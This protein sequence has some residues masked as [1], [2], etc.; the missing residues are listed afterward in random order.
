[1]EILCL[2][3][4]PRNGVD[5]RTVFRPDNGFVYVQPPRPKISVHGRPYGR[6]T[7]RMETGTTY[8]L[9]Y[10]L[11]DLPI[12]EKNLTSPVVRRKVYGKL[13]TNTTNKLSYTWPNG[14]RPKTCYPQSRLG[15]G[16]SPM[17]TITVHSS[18]YINPG[19]VTTKS[20]KCCRSR[21]PVTAPMESTTIARESYQHPGPTIKSRSMTN[22]SKNRRD[23][24]LSIKP[25]YETIQ[26]L[27]YQRNLVE[28]PTLT[29]SQRRERAIVSAKIGRET[30]YNTSYMIPG[31]FVKVKN[32]QT[33][34]LPA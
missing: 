11:P 32:S 20:A 10:M 8:R 28:E 25:D 24:K 27:S 23:W 13:D 15:C 21:R 31:C 6:R 33:P 12:K 30:T 3:P 7:T 1:M 26:R 16:K 17:E 18:S 14:Q 29:R 34:H 4:K 9:S 19:A 2:P 5:E 22:W